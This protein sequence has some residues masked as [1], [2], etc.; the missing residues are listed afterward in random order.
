MAELRLVHELREHRHLVFVVRDTGEAVW[1]RDELTGQEWWYATA[2]GVE[3]LRP[4]VA[5]LLATE[6]STVLVASPVDD[7]AGQRPGHAVLAKVQQLHEAATDVDGMPGVLD[8]T[9]TAWC[10]GFVGEERVGAALAT[11]PPGWR[12]LHA[13]P[14]G[15]HA[16]IDHVVIGPPGV[17]VVN[18][19]H[20]QGVDVTAGTHAVFVAGQP[21]SY[22]REIR[23]DAADAT[24]AL[25]DVAAPVHPVICLV[26][27]RRLR[28]SSPADD[29]TVVTE[30]LLVAALTALPA[31]LEPAEVEAAYDR[32]RRA[33][34]WT[35]RPP[36]PAAHPWVAEYARGL[37]VEERL[38]KTHRRIRAPRAAATRRPARRPRRRLLSLL[39]ALFVLAGLLAMLVAAP[40]LAR[41][42]TDGMSAVIG[43]PS[44]PPPAPTPAAGDPCPTKGTQLTTTSGALV[45]KKTPDGSL[46]WKPASP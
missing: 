42:A 35:S 45:C 43:G 10:V 6:G 20:H 36:V 22:L 1:A 26:G 18:T 23:G 9:V 15:A 3:Q 13:V 8:D 12:V 29:V 34:S 7:L 21:K 14:V 5:R 40:L 16:D 44:A 33:S 19:K 41:L 46:H 28:H 2:S 11:L 17:V 30:P 27:A 32:L 37:A 24:A 39:A 31:R 4:L 38:V 25:G